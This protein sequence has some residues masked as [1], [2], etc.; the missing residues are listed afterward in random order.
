MYILFAANIKGDPKINLVAI[1][2]VVVSIL[3][4]KNV[5][6]STGQIYQRRPIEMLEIS[7]HFNLLILC[8]V[9]FFTLENKAVKDIF[10]QISMSVTMILLLGVL[11]YHLLVEG[12]FKTRFWKQYKRARG[13]TVTLTDVKDTMVIE[14]TIPSTSVIEAPH[15]PCQ[16]LRGKDRKSSQ[17][18]DMCQ[19]RETLLD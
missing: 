2:L 3:L 15:Q 8:V 7:C 14:E 13:Y 9:S 16:H 1:A 6:E 18:N 12:I 10:A 5:A 4:T 11:L 19:L 17:T